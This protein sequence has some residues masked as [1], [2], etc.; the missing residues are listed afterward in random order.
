MVTLTCNVWV[1]FRYA[2]MCERCA[3][4]ALGIV[5]DSWY[6]KGFCSVIPSQAALHGL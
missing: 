6:R 5:G 4:W 1:N 2:M 3:P